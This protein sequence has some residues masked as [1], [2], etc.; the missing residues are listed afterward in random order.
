M[1]KT[2][3]IIAIKGGVGKTTTT[4]NLGAVLAEDFDKKV[5]LVDANFSAPNLG[6][7]VGLVDP[8]T[9]LHDVLL[10]R[11][12]I[13]DSVYEYSEN[14]HIIPGALIGKK[15][16]PFLL[17][18]KLRRIKRKYDIVL[19]DSSPALNHEILSTMIASDKLFVVST[20]DYPTLST[21]MRAIKIAKQKKTPIA[22]IIL[23]KVK[24]KK[25]ELKIEDIEEAAGVPVVAVLP[26][27]IK[28]L[29]A[30]SLTK[31][32]AEHAPRRDIVHE[33][34]HLAACIVGEDYKDTRFKK[35]I[36]R[37]FS[38]DIPREEANRLLVREQHFKR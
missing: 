33:Y 18:E 11:A 20:P 30:L 34:R 3:G 21:T 10:K 6:L 17:K 12:D 31:H 15:V 28:M 25:F 19:L 24:N 8:E 14:L 5:L 9:T 29:E 4:L 16:S 38:R 35:K 32:I 7:H 2:I 36:K 27:D 22:G 1:G 13:D 26:D 37:F 23:N